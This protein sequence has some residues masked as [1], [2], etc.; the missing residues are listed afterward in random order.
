MKLTVKNF[1]IPLLSWYQLHHRPLIFRQTKQPYHIWISEIMAQQ[2][3]IV[4]ML[5]YYQRWIEKW[6]SIHDLAL[7]EENE[8]LKAWE[9]LGYYSRAKNIHATAKYLAKNNNGHFPKTYDEM[10]TLKGIGDYSASAI[11]AICFEQDTPAID[12]NVIRVM[13]RVLADGRDF[14]KSKNKQELRQHLQSL[15]LINQRGDFVQAMMELGALICTPANPKCS[16]CPLRQICLANA[17]KRQADFPTKRAKKKSPTIVLDVFV[18][19]K[20]QQIVLSKDDSDHLL[21]GLYRLPFR[22]AHKKELPITT[23]KHV[24]SHLVWQLNLYQVD[25]W[26]CNEFEAYYDLQQI[27]KLPMITAHKKLL[28]SVINLD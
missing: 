5:P 23:L 9:G 8:V 25:N 17:S 6:P 7:A 20:N 15:M 3:Q 21:Q 28:A 12:G 10:I 1:T 19:V 11:A 24:F 13:S 26:Q 14:L 16:D 4:T 18:V 2:T 27:N 22:P